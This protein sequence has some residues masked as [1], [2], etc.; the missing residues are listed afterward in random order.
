MRLYCVL[1]MPTV[2]HKDFE[3]TQTED[4][5]SDIF[6][7][8]D[9]ISRLE[10]GDKKI[11]CQLTLFQSK[12]IKVS[13]FE[14]EK[15]QR[16]VDSLSFLMRY[17]IHS[18]NGLFNYSI[19]IADGE[20]NPLLQKSDKVLDFPCDIYNKIKEFYHKH[21]FHKVDDGD[22][23]IK[24][25]IS[26]NTVDI[27]LL[28]NDALKHYLSQYEKKF[29]NGL[30]YVGIQ[31]DSLI[32]RSWFG[33]FCMLMLGKGKHHSFY[34]LITRIKGD[35]AYYNSLLYSCYN[36]I[37]D[38][39]PIREGN[40][41]SHDV[42]D[43][44]RRIFNVSNSVEC[45]NVMEERINN[46]FNIQISVISFWVAILAILLSVLFYILSIDNDNTSNSIL[47]LLLDIWSKIS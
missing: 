16:K 25:Y 29:L 3:S 38:L 35:K 34:R 17:V 36:T 15:T 21:N 8:S 18:H 32:E 28:D 10:T 20:E 5:I 46:I 41:L 42:K 33:N 44:R 27:C 22:S 1:W 24:P 39:S 47:L 43:S 40:P 7:I 9:E 14:D 31:Y 6:E 37:S 2:V 11:Y 26:D 45:L 23:M 19:D 30:K 13:I 12:D 4:K